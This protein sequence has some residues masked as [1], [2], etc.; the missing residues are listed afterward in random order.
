MFAVSL[1]GKVPRAQ[2]LMFIAGRAHFRLALLPSAPRPQPNRAKII[3]FALSNLQ[4]TQRQQPPCRRTS[5][6]SLASL[7][8]STLATVRL[9]TRRAPAAPTRRRSA[10]TELLEEREDDRLTVNAEVTPR[11]PAARISRRKGFLSKRT[12]FVREITREV[13]GY[14]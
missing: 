14:V 1:E 5:S 6:R 7:P 8:A 4:L 12:A 9:P 3:V 13:A 2:T 11:T 10:E